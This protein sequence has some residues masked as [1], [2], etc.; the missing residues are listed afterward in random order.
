[1]NGSMPESES[2][3][4]TVE[5]IETVDLSELKVKINELLYVVLPGKTTLNDMETLALKV[6]D[7]IASFIN[8]SCL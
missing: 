4:A 6:F 7:D 2:S 1:M 5:F 8:P 3:L